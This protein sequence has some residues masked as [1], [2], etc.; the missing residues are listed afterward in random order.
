MLAIFVNFS[1]YFGGILAYLILAIPIFSNAYAGY[2]PAEL[3]QLISNYSFQSQYLIYLFTRLYD[4]L[5]EI[6]VV[7][8]N[9]KRV[10]ELT[11][12]MKL[13]ALNGLHSSKPDRRVNKSINSVE[14]ISS[15]DVTVPFDDSRFL[16]IDRVTIR[17]PNSDRVLINNL[18]FEFKKGFVP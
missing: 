1:Q 11:D 6:S 12:K 8:G 4:T 14:P 10:G 17:V 5:S 3:A 7:A 13:L 9:C 18:S 16:T 15:N 2:T